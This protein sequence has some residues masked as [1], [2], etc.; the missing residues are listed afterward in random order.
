MLVGPTAVG[1]T[2]VSIQ[3][4]K[5]MGAEILSADS[6]QIYRE[7]NIGSAKPTLVEMQ[8][9][10]HHMLGITPVT[11]P[12][13][14]AARFQRM[15]MDC[16][17]DIL[18]RGKTPLITGGTGLYVHALTHPLAFTQVPGNPDVRARLLA[19]EASS[20]GALYRRLQEADPVSAGK[21]HPN[22]SKRVVRAL[23]V[24][25]VSGRPLSA[26]GTDFHNTQQAQTK[27][28][29]V[30]AGLYME[31]EKLYERINFRVDQMLEAGLLAEV[32]G[33]LPYDRALPALQ[34]LGYK[35]LLRYFDGEME[36]EACIETIKQETRR[37]AKRQGTWFKRDAR[38]EWFD[39]TN[40]APDA[41]LESILAYFEAPD[42]AEEE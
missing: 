32:K 40:T 21:L 20:P 7:L 35:Q 31:R 38:I 16:I 10:P 42:G 6:M 5:R 1:K 8:G 41:L 3:L 4:A 14:S 25:E 18:S 9:V 30:I 27:Y 36:Y 28:L 19:D 23:E 22:D 2:A 29:P 12:G 11:D 17:G 13:F 33:L 34:G 26:F 15:A 39:C 37:F 24:Y